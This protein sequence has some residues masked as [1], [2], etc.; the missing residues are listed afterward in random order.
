MITVAIIVPFPIALLFILAGVIA[1]STITVRTYRNHSGRIKNIRK[2]LTNL[3]SE[4][5]FVDN[6]IIEEEDIF[7]NISL[8]ILKDLER[9]IFKLVEKNVQ[10]LSL[11]E[12]GRTIIS[13]L[14]EKKLVESVFDYLMH[15]IGYKEVAFIIVRRKTE[16]LQGII[17]IE[18]NNKISKRVV[19]FG[20]NDLEGAIFNSLKTGKSFLIKD[21]DL[22]PIEEIDEK[23][24]FPGSTMSS[25]ICVPL[26]KSSGKPELGE[27]INCVLNSGIDGKN[28]KLRDPYLTDSSC[29][30]C[31]QMS[32]LGLLIVTDGYRATPLTNI[33]QVTVETVGSLVSS[34]IENWMLYQELRQSEKFREKVFEGMSHGLVVTDLNGKINFANRSAKLM[35][36]MGTKIL[37][38][39]TVFDLVSDMDS[40]KNGASFF[41]ML[42]RDDSVTFHEGYLKRADGYHIPIRLNVSKFLGENNEVQGAIVLFVDLSDIKKM[43]E[44]IHHLDRLALLGRF[45]SA[46]AHEIR[47]P[48]TGIGAGVQ[49]LR[50]SSNF[51]DEQNLSID[52]ILSEVERLDRI[53]S[54]LFKVAKPRDILY[55]EAD[56]SELIERSYNS[57]KEMFTEKG[58]E[59]IK[60]IDDNVL[61]I[62]V[63]PDQM[64][65]VLINLIKN[66]VEATGKGGKVIARVKCYNEMINERNIKEQKKIV[67]IEIIDNGIGIDKKSIGRIFEPFFSNKSQGTGLGLFISH[68][69]I[70]HHHG[71]IDAF[72]RENE[73]TTIQINLPIN[74][75]GR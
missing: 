3:K 69:I 17:S 45:T 4:G 48:L 13:S 2:R 39:L 28:M 60:D 8:A 65:Q 30:S 29:L 35:T 62:E 64:I 54:D 44:E 59:F 75:H 57:V 74:K 67:R 6:R 15:G 42:R 16:T 49:Y 55:Q 24:L 12:I 18:K 27:M 9:T 56:L 1:V 50:R 72:S 43:E 47:N 38:K 73:G 10:L 19:N 51:S 20:I 23:K 31:N 11:K 52:S 5:L 70:Q 66:A 63:D 53:I 36:Q 41:D 68:S 7:Y 22:H 46:I 37:E 34:N 21:I 58:V 61:P 14:D 26:I 32:L 40:D 71:K 25:Y 33:D